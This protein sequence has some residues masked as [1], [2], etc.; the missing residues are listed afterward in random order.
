LVQTVDGLWLRAEP[1][2]A[3]APIQLREGPA[4]VAEHGFFKSWV[5]HPSCATEPVVKSLE[6]S[7]ID[8][9]IDRV[10][11]RC[12]GEWFGELHFDMTIIVERQIE[13]LRGADDPRRR[14]GLEPADD[15]ELKE[16][17]AP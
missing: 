14:L 4:S 13:A 10:E 9:W 3:K 11:L 17:K 1:G 15:D 5:T 6:L 8:G 16:W 7:G 2:T 12:P